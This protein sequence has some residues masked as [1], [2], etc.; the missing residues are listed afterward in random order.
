M[1][2]IE[3]EIRGLTPLMQHKMPHEVLLGLIPNDKTGKKKVKEILTPR[4]IAEKH[5]YLNDSGRFCIPMTYLT[6]AFIAASSEYKQKDSSRKSLKS[7]AGGVFRPMSGDAEILDFDGNPVKDFEVD[8]RKATNHQRGAVAAI[9]P[10]FDRWMVKTTFRIDDSLVPAEMVHQI[11][12]DA[13]R[14][15]GI[16]S[17][18][19]QKQGWFGQYEITNWKVL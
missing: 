15:I 19:V 12:E 16:G 13:G 6:G 9:R 5:V 4:E 11:L 14:R 18:R 8:I 10:R 2:T 3:I 7:I 1:K 17:Y